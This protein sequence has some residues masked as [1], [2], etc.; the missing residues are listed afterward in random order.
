MNTLGRSITS[1]FFK[2]PEDY[3]KLREFWAQKMQE[4]EKLSAAHH[5]LYMMLIGKNWAKGFTLAKKID[6]LYQTGYFRAYEKIAD[7]RLTPQFNV[8]D[9]FREFLSENI[10][11]KILLY[12]PERDEIF[13]A[14]KQRSL[15]SYKEPANV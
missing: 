11:E 8:F 3:V 7:A 10:E 4:R 2:S 15:R 9:F 14:I 13:E 5:A 1:T 12:L 6:L